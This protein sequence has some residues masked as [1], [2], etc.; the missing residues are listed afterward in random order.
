MNANN[1]I[2]RA[3]SIASLEF[4]C[5]LNKLKGW[6]L[7]LVLG[8]A[9]MEDIAPD[10]QRTN[11]SRKQNK[12]AYY[13]SMEFL[14]GR[15]IFNNLYCA[16]VLEET[17]RLLKA[18]GIDLRIL[19]DLEDYAFGNGGL[20][21]LAACYLDSAAAHDI[22][23]MGYGL[24]Y[25]FGLFKQS[26]VDARQAEQPDNWSEFGDPFSIRRYDLRLI[27]S[28]GDESVIAVPYDLPIIGYEKNS[29]GTLRLWQTEALQEVD[30]KLFNTQQYEE[31]AAAKNKAED[32]CKF[33]Y[34][35]DSGDEGKLLRIKQEYLLSSASMQDI[36]RSF[37]AIHGNDYASLPSFAALQLNDTHPA[38]AIPE[39]IRLL[40]AYGVDFYTAFQIARN[41]FSYTNHTVMSEA[42]E[43]WEARLLKQAVPQIFPIIRRINQMLLH[44]L[45]R[46]DL[47]LVKNQRVNM[48]DLSIYAT[49]T[50][51]GVAQ[52]HSQILKDSLFS[53]W[54]SV[55]PERFT[56]ITNGITQ[57]RWLA[58]CNPQLS[59]LITKTL[60]HDEYIYKL[61]TLR[62]GLS[63]I[64]DSLAQDF[65]K[66]KALKKQELAKHIYQL[67]G[68][69]IPPHFVFDVQIKRMHEYKRQLMNALSIM[70]IYQ[71]LK[72]GSIT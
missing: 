43:K 54:Y 36:L 17:D 10:W 42:L 35:N 15:M 64:D 8:E 26:F 30:F 46:P 47:S 2:K 67:E 3:E 24:R 71:G 32:L 14:I 63:K 19:E 57:R 38:M 4:Q 7:G 56:N 41:T 49:H 12:Q 13:L 52:I 44:E 34:P 27:I 31:A 20:G 5:S 37:R 59:E 9:L 29:I 66:V 33:L 68:I 40:E 28:L 69:Q 23:L 6:Q 45:K 62:D 50:T 55:Y 72:D 16:G 65:I 60:E 61:E 25:K 39:L 48:A 21:R 51:N 22:P 53:D 18:Q 58:L 1:L 11:E 70:A